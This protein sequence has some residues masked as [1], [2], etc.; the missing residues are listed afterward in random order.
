MFPLSQRLTR[1][2]FLPVLL[3]LFLAIQIP[4]L[5]ADPHADLAPTSRDAYTDEG[6][7][8]SQVINRVNHGKWVIDECDNL[9]KT[10]LFSLWLLPAYALFG[11]STLVGRVW[12]LVGCLLL[13]YFASRKHPVLPWVL[14]TFLLISFTE[15]HLFQYV[16]FTMAELTACFLVLVA[17]SYAIRYSMRLKIRDVV[18]SG[19]F[20][21]AAVSVK[22]QFAYTLVLLPVWLLII[23]GFQEKKWTKNAAVAF[24]VSFATLALG[25]VIYYVGWY[26]PTKATYDYV[27]ADQAGGRFMPLSL[28]HEMKTQAEAFLFSPYT[29]WYTYFSLAGL[30]IF[31]A[32]VIRSKNKTFRILSLLTLIWALLELHK[33]AMWYVPARYLSPLLFAWGLFAAIQGVWA[34]KNALDYGVI[35]KIIAGVALAATIALIIHQISFIEKLYRERTFVIHETNLRLLSVNFD[36]RPVAGPWAPAL[37]RETGARVIP[38]W[39]NYFND[40][41]LIQRFSPKIIISEKD[42]GDSG[43]AYKNQGIDLFALADSTQEVH[44]GPYDLVIYYLP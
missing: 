4:F 23:Q 3:L 19:I 22:N 36:N 1:P 25:A 27:M 34:I 8:T 14:G 28:F 35:P 16:R 31:V 26:L 12:V 10:P 6:L 32:N 17:L 33:F 7:N 29:R 21:W 5:Q 18:W 43:G 30:V 44:I 11:T 20:L 2:G 37:A 39:F 13:L 41:N 9:I 15:F 40:K 24:L 38:V 42:E